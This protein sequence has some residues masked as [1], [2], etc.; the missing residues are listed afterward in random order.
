MEPICDGHKFLIRII[1]CF[2]AGSMRIRK[3]RKDF[4]ARH[5]E[6]TFVKYVHETNHRG[7]EITEED[8][9]EKTKKELQRPRVLEQIVLSS[10]CC[11]PL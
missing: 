2:R 8:N 1:S 6:R 5:L 9:T 10:L 11:L 4:G 7:T 3:M